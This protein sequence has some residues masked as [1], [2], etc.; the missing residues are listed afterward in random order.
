MEIFK[1]FSLASEYLF[2]LPYITVDNG[3]EE[4]KIQEYTV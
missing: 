3:G 4:W 1:I 2:S